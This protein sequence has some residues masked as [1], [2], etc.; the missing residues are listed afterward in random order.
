MSRLEQ[1]LDELGVLVDAQLFDLAFTHRS[2]AYEN[3]RAESNER[4]EFLGDAVLQI[5]VT[6][7][8]F[9]TYPLLAEG[10]M[11]KLRASVVSSHA[12]ASVARSLGLGEHIK[13]GKGEV[14][15]GGSGKSSILADTMEALIG[16]VHISRGSE[17][18]ET[19]VH[20][21]FDQLI[22]ESE[23]AGTYTDF[24][25]ALQELCSHRGWGAPVYEID[26]AG[27]DHERIFTAVVFVD[28]KAVSTG[29]APSKKTAEQRAAT[30]AHRLLSGS[31]DA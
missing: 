12:L 31:Q 11:A 1:K 22:A 29:T 4:L 23:E 18:S 20:G 25:T 8:I 30:S 2:W 5:V 19:F 26:G 3:G 27:P 7:H 24:K 17:A 13:L 28:G 15:T 6:E 10:H 21:V 9:R 16:A 14:A